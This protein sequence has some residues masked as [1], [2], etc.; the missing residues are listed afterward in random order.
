MFGRKKKSIRVPLEEYEFYRDKILEWGW[1]TQAFDND[2][3]K[4]VYKTT[5]KGVAVYSAVVHLVGKESLVNGYKLDVKVMEGLLV[6]ETMVKQET[7]DGLLQG[8]II[9]QTY[10]PN[11]DTNSY[12]LTPV[13][14]KIFVAFFVSYNREVGTLPGDATAKFFDIMS[15]MPQYVNTASALISQLGNAF[16]SFDGQSGTAPQVP[17]QQNNKP[18]YSKKQKQAYAKNKAKWKKENA[19]KRKK[20]K[21]AKARPKAKARTKSKKQY[22]EPKNDYS[23]LGDQMM[24][25]MF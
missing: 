20:K 8:N 15:K 7:I 12:E 3:N 22:R 5:E 6:A 10:D 23:N 1:L 19:Q 21:K 17:Q 18:K 16:Q 25:D 24:K 14:A 11:A 13:G 2:R 4:S 9:T